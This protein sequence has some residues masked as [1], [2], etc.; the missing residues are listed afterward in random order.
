MLAIVGW[1]VSPGARANAQS[2]PTPSELF[3]RLQSPKT[4]YE[5]SKQF[6]LYSKSNP[7]FRKY[8]IDHLGSIISPGPNSCPPNDIEDIEARW[9]PCPWYNAVKLAGELKI[10]ESVPA[11]G[12]WIA[13]R[14]GDGVVIGL[15]SEYRLD[16]YPV[17]TALW[18]IGNPSIPAV[19][20]AFDSDPRVHFVAVRV[21]CI[22]NTPQSKAALRDDLTR[23]SEPT[24]RVMIK[25]CSEK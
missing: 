1:A 7:L 6:L 19:Q 17:A 23:E 24:L 18:Q 21:L 13:F 12:P 14:I 4:T 16:L 20:N 10:G 11:L 8:L 9:H 22:I 15:S 5:A 3:R 2:H 25:N